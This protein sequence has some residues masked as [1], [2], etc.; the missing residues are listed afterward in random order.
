[1]VRTNGFV[2]NLSLSVIP[3][4]FSPLWRKLQEYFLKIFSSFREDLAPK[5]EA[6]TNIT[7]QTR[8][9]RQFSGISVAVVLLALIKVIT[10]PL[11]Q[12]P[13]DSYFM[14]YLMNIK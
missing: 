7:Q 4:V 13:N 2:S 12:M 6:G 8:S 14:D 11:R 9:Q 1:M 5:D 3:F 10:Y